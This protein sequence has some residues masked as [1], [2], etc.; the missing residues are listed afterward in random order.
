MRSKSCLRDCLGGKNIGLSTDVVML[1]VPRDHYCDLDPLQRLP[2]N[3]GAMLHAHA[4]TGNAHK[5]VPFESNLPRAHLPRALSRQ[6]KA[7]WKIS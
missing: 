7:R 6:R 1:A 3:G 5:K 4:M 2:Q